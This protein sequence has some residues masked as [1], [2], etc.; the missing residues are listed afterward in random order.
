LPLPVVESIAKSRDLRQFLF[1][2]QTTHSSNRMRGIWIGAA[3]GALAWG[4]LLIMLLMLV[5]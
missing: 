1:A 4:C 5:R 2:A 3:L